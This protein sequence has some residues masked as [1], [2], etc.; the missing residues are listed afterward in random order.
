MPATE[1]NPAHAMTATDPARATAAGPQPTGTASPAVAHPWRRALLCFG[2]VLALVAL[3]L[4]SKAAVFAWFEDPAA[5]ADFVRTS[6]GHVRYPLVGDWLAF[7]ENLNYGAAF[8][9]G[10][11]WPWVLV[12]G[13]GVAVV[14][15]SVLVVRVPR[16]QG[17]YLASL[18][19]I[20]AGALGNLYDNLFY[21]PRF[22]VEGKP[23]GPVRDFIDVYFAVWDWHFPTFNVADSCITVGAVLLL[24]SG[25]FAKPPAEVPTAG[26]EG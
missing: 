17:L 19:L 24:V 18:V 10:D 25:F 23:F 20:L 7:M 3:D 9:Q 16:G 26:A 21:E 2:V 1:P 6:H 14:L 4:W 11:E 8:G 15:L 22:P 13:R 5:T 12:L